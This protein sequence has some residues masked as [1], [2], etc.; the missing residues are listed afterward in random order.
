LTAPFRAKPYE[1]SLM[2]T[3]EVSDLAAFSQLIPR[4][5]KIAS[6]KFERTHFEKHGELMIGI[7]DPLRYGF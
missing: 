2:P 5:E 1:T 3:L 7:A 4:I 6:R